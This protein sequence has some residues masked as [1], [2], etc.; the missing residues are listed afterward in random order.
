MLI[1]VNGLF[2]QSCNPRLVEVQIETRL[3]IKVR[4]FS[5]LKRKSFVDKIF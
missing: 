3:D 4:F 1:E 2:T 5:N